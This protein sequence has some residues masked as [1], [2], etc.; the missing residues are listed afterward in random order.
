MPPI[1]NDVPNAINNA[2]IQWKVA[3]ILREFSKVWRQYSTWKSIN[4]EKGE[5]CKSVGI[6]ECSPIAIQLWRMRKSYQSVCTIRAVP[7]QIG[8]SRKGEHH[9][10]Q[11]AISRVKINYKTFATFERWF[12]CFLH[13]IY[14]MAI[15]RVKINY[16]TFANFERWICCLFHQCT[17]PW[18]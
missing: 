9:I 4:P 7:P 10:Y 17:P 2:H 12:C 3:F 1:V 8:P 13:H 15:S 5:S 14:Q 18:P 16:K 11:M 6:G